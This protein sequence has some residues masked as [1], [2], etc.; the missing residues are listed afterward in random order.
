MFLLSILSYNEESLFYLFEILKN[1]SDFNPEKT[2][3]HIDD[4]VKRREYGIGGKP[5][6]CR[7]ANEKGVGCGNCDL[8]QKHKWAKVGD[9]YIETDEYASPSPIRFAYNYKKE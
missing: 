5:Y 3:S 8:E 4:W 6:T 2:Q 7:T 1:C 9:H